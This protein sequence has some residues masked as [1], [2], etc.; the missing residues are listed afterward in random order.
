MPANQK[1]NNARFSL[2]QEPAYGTPPLS[3]IW[4]VGGVFSALV[5]DK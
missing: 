3:E 2:D 4:T 5:H 1:S